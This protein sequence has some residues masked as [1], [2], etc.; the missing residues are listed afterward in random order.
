MM[1]EVHICTHESRN[2][3]EVPNAQVHY[4]SSSLK[5]LADVKKQWLDLMDSIKPDVVHVNCCWLPLCSLVQKWSQNR[6]VKV[7]LSPHG[8][9]EPWIVKRNYWTKKLPALL[10]Y[11][12]EAIKSADLIH[13]TAESE[14]ENILKL[15]YNDKVAVVPNSVDLSEIKLKDEWSIKRQALFL[16][17]VH[18]KKGV[19]L[20]I[21][22]VT[23]LRG[24]GECLDVSFIVAGEGDKEY[25][26]GIQ[27]R[28]VEREL[29]DVVKLVGGIYGEQKWMAY[30]N[31]DVFVLPTFSE[32][33]GIA[34]A[35]ALASGTPVITT[36]GTPWKD[37]ET[38]SCGCWIKTDV[39]SLA[40][41]LRKM[42]SL[43]EIELK[44][45]GFN[46]RRLIERKY[47]A[48]QT[49]KRMFELYKSLM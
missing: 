28:I 40:D 19:E 14:K 42:L 2:P 13:A 6:G 1:A 29:Q 34:I 4:F 39:K 11:Q 31:A 37:L 3:V 49:A 7:V 35:E 25:R 15:K 48:E 12:K 33:F 16:S 27:R 38:D 10:L 44:T 20:L 30:R 18:V 23:E 5:R 43:N 36:Q 8:M 41:A 21:D 24:G 46:A 26:E 45:L 22:A 47:S 32:N 9:L 17:R